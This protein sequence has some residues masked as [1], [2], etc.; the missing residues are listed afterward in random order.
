MSV[1]YLEFMFFTLSII[2]KS[3]LNLQMKPVISFW[4]S[5]SLV[6]RFC[7]DGLSSSPVSAW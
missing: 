6:Q 1:V 4:L 7:C 3:L 2:L 5:L